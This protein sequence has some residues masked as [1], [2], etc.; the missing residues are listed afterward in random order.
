MK[1]SFDGLSMHLI[2]FNLMFFD[3]VSC[4]EILLVIYWFSVFS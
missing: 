4:F 3:D 1:V 2:I